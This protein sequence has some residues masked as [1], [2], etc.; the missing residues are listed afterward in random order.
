MSRDPAALATRASAAALAFAL[1]TLL[2]VFASARHLPPLGTDGLIYHLPLAAWWL[3]EGWLAPVDLPFHGGGSEHQPALSHTLSLLLMRLTGDDGLVWLVQPASLLALA[4][5]FLRSAR[6]LGAG[7]ALAWGLTA[8]L[9]LFPPHVANV[10]LPNNDLLFLLGAA[11]ALHGLLLARR[12]PGSGAACL[13][14]G[15]GLALAT[16][17][18]GT[19]LLVVLFPFALPALVRAWRGTAAAPAARRALLRGLG[20]GAGLLLLGSGFLWR[21]LFLHGNPL[22]PGRLRLA[23]RTVFEGPYDLSILVDHGWAPA[24]IGELL[25]DGPEQHALV[26]PWSPLLWLGWGL[27]WLALARAPARRRGWLRA[28]LA[29]G[30]A[31]LHFAL[32]FAQVPF[33]VEPRYHLPTYY[34][35]WLALAYGLAELRRR[36]RGKVGPW[37]PLGPPLFLLLLILS[38]G[39]AS[40]WAL[41]GG[42]VTAAAAFT[43]AARQVRRHLPRALLVAGALALLAGPLWYPGYRAAREERRA[44]L[45]GVH[46]GLQGEA[47]GLLLEAAAREGP[48]TVAYAGTP[49]VFPLFGARLE[50]RVV[51]LRL[52]ADDREAPLTLAPRPPDVQP[53]FWMHESIARARRARVDEAFWLAELER[54]RPGWLLLAEVPHRGGVAQELGLVARHPARFQ[55]VAHAREE[56]GRGV[57]LYRVVG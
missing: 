32:T 11:L 54:L 27:A 49:L 36:D 34:G 24:A 14:L 47:W 25:W 21:S 56:D 57:W 37:V 18:T 28:A 9:L 48:L 43:P 35:L 2:M 8:L 29:L 4:A 12:S 33:W 22:W 13:G 38:L 7:R 23:G 41:A 50:N 53:G 19:L 16:K 55:L 3:Q 1:L 6:L 30:F 52:S 10:Q 17:S 15:L 40:G 51:Y 26:I 45:Y 5:V 44:R 20:A 31:P 42:A 39:G 46:Y